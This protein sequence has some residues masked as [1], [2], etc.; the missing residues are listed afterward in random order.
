MRWIKKLAEV[1]LVC[2]AGMAH[3]ASLDTGVNWLKAQQQA[4]GAYVAGND[5]ALA[6]QSTSELVAT[7]SALNVPADHTQALG[8][9]AVQEVNTEWLA[10]RIIASSWAG[11]VASNADIG[12]LLANQNE[13]GGFGALPGY[14]S[15][16]LDTA[17][18]LLARPSED[19][20]L[21]AANWLINKQAGN[22]SWPIAADDDAVISTAMAVQALQPYRNY[23][24]I[25]AALLKARAWLDA[26]VQA[27][28]QRKTSTQQVLH[29]WAMRKAPTVAGSI[30]P[31]P[32]PWL[33]GR[34]GWGRNPI[35]TNLTLLHCG[36]I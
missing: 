27:D 31:T 29:N 1:A 26:Q 23:S 33:S 17:W 9:L 36:I 12:A 13:D 15:N 8:F 5:I 24:G 19:S 14:D 10:R 4:S 22:G 35:C 3:A 32:Q 18:A 25:S 16:V 11:V 30:Q 34:C 6:A 2:L 21:L 7:F 28:Q 20:T